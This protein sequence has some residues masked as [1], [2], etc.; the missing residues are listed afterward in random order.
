MKNSHL[1][2]FSSSSHI[3]TQFWCSFLIAS[4]NSD[5][6]T[7]DT[8]LTPLYSP[9]PPPPSN[10]CR[11]RQHS[12][13]LRHSCG[14]HHHTSCSS[15]TKPVTI[16]TL[17]FC[18]GVDARVGT[19]VGGRGNRG[20]AVRWVGATASWWWQTRIRT[21]RRRRFSEICRGVHPRL[22]LLSFWCTPY[23]L[24]CRIP[25]LNR[26]FL[27]FNTVNG[28]LNCHVI[29]SIGSLVPLD[30]Q[31][32]RVGLRQILRDSLRTLPRAALE[33]HH[34]ITTLRS[35]AGRMPLTPKGR[36]CFWD[37]FFSHFWCFRRR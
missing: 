15:A 26:Y 31:A 7:A 25:L 28:K 21:R 29:T 27:L 11:H 23:Y 3:S 10:C 20:C 34:E 4:S 19:E 8:L 13:D 30:A 35:G 14:H 1:C 12:R 33:P 22:A 36:F 2:C 17:Q 16:A 18:V 9:P 6:V 32:T 5:L 24:L 37:S